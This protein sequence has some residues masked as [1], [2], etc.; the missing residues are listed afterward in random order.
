MTSS[1]PRLQYLRRYAD[2][3]ATSDDVKELENAI[4]SDIVF[5]Q[6][7]VEY[8]HIDSGLEEFAVEREERT[9]KPTPH[10]S[11]S[12]EFS[13]PHT[14]VSRR[15]WLAA[16]TAIA[17]SAFGVLMWRRK[18]PQGPGQSV[19]VLE[20][21]HPSLRAGQRKS[22]QALQWATGE[23]RLKLSSNVILRV[24]APLDL[25]LIDAMHVLVKHGKVLADV[26]ENGTGFTIDTLNAR[27]IDLGTRFGVDA[28]NEQW[29]DVV[30]FSGSVE[31]HDPNDEASKMPIARLV[32]GQAV[33]MREKRQLARIHSIVGGAD[34][35]DWSSQ[36]ASGSKLISQVTDNIIGDSDW[37]FYRIQPAAMR[38][39]AIV[40]VDRP[41][42]WE[43]V[44]GKEFPGSLM[45]ADLVQTFR[46]ARRMRRLELDIHFKSRA[47]LFVL[48][49]ERGEKP[50]WEV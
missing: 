26:G 3:V 25:E 44:Q 23:A 24:S 15:S 19:L 9:N 13:V 38:P 37:F 50:D 1:D 6:L 30:V 49:P 29:T 46:G 5:R 10:R 11:D 43:S 39:G 45:G 41:H 7:V 32:Q 21:T 36:D 14:H 28:R 48:M 47:E 27:V 35:D 4:A 20:S 16:A 12:V 31:L 42:T 22:L 33:S 8:L 34:P 40:H 2:G 18:G 17:A